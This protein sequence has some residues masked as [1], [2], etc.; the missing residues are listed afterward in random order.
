MPNARPNILVLMTDQQRMDTISAYG[1]NPTCR[2]PRIDEL[3]GRGVRFN[4]AFTPTAICSPARASFYTGLYPHKHGVTANGL[5]LKEGVRGINHYLEEAGSKLLPGLQFGLGPLN[6]PNHYE[7]Y[8]K[9]RGLEIPTVSH[10]YVGTNP[11]N[12][13]Q[14]M[15]ALHDG[16]VESSI[17]YFVAEETIRVLEQ[18]SAGDRPFFLW[19]NFW[20]PHT[21]CLV[22]EPYFSIVRS[23]GYSCTPQLL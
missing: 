11:N 14:E 13:A 15:F 2:T 6:R 4:N 18:L 22:P 21:P 23:G 16:P 1:L 3:A 7:V 9:E 17:E 12:Q 20:G 5:C 8:L 19:G 10:S